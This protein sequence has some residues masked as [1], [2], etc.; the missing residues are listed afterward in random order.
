MMGPSL[1]K[2]RDCLPN[3]LPGMI[4]IML[5]CA[6]SVKTL[7]TLKDVTL[8]TAKQIRTV[9]KLEKYDDLQAYAEQYCPRTTAWFRSC[10]NYPSKSEVRA[11]ILD[12]LLGTFG[13]EHLFKTSEGLS[14][15][16]SL[17][18]DKLVCVYCNAGDTYA[19]TLICYRG[20]WQV[21]CWG[22]IAERYM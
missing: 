9:I 13:V 22:D 20:R 1:K 6:P 15:N 8:A 17:P 21:G 3:F 7:C 5:T 18:S 11:A 16:C 14:G 10:C 19:A 2:L 12:E 4:Y